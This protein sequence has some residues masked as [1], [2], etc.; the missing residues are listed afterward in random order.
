ADFTVSRIAVSHACPA[1][2]LRNDRNSYRPVSAGARDRRICWMSSKSSTAESL[3]GEQVNV[4]PSAHGSLWSTP[5]Q[6][7][8]NLLRPC[9]GRLSKSRRFVSPRCHAR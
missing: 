6:Q 8:A 4:I 9:E 7:Y 1:G 5:S 2:A 3:G